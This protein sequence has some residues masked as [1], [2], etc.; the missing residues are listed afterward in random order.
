MHGLE[1]LWVIT[2]LLVIFLIIYEALV[3]GWYKNGIYHK[4]LFIMQIYGLDWWK[5]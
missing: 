4:W 5:I 2:K 3:A 1:I